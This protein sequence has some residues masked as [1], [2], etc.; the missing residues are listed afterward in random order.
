MYMYVVQIV[1]LP[2]AITAE[3]HQIKDQSVALLYSS[4]VTLRIFWLVLWLCLYSISQKKGNTK[5]VTLAK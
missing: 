3:W 4:V 5:F 2:R 1:Y